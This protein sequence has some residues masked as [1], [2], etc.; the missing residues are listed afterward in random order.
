MHHSENGRIG[1]SEQNQTMQQKVKMKSAPNSYTDSRRDLMSF[2]NLC[3]EIVVNLKC[4]KMTAHS[5]LYKNESVLRCPLCS[6][7]FISRKSFLH[8]VKLEHS[9]EKNENDY[10]I[11]I[12]RNFLVS[13]TNQN[14]FPKYQFISLSESYRYSNQNKENLL[15]TD[16]SEDSSLESSFT[17]SF[18]HL[19]SNDTTNKK[20]ELESYL[21]SN[22][23]RNSISTMGKK[24]F[25]VWQSL[26][27]LKKLW[28][29]FRIFC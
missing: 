3:G 22:S 29:C 16:S 9:G 21:N 23:D 1:K 4:H 20:L 12:K 13:L 2:C 17:P 8:H 5:E 28:V 18:W 19:S 27:N 7:V 24:L 14:V 10:K 11:K 26:K 15:I 25:Q 6:I